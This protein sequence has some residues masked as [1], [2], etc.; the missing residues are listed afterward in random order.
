VEE[1]AEILE[2]AEE[3]F[4]QDQMKD[5]LEEKIEKKDQQEILEIGHHIKKKNSEKRKILEPREISEL[6]K[7]LG[8][9]KASE[10]THLERDANN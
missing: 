7:I 1:T 5:D 8:P 9:K 4:L 2:L 6:R 10:T 3:H